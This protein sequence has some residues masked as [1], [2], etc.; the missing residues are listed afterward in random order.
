MRGPKQTE[1]PQCGI[2]TAFNPATYRAKVHLPLLST[3]TDWIRVGS[4]YVGAGW[5]LRTPL[6]TGNEVL[7][8]FPNGD[9]N[10]GII[11]CALWS[12]DC[13][14]T[15]Q[16]GGNFCLVHES[17]SLLRFG[18]DGSIVIRASNVAIERL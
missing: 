1:L 9:L 13:D 4:T 15:P 17:G 18:T 8:N 14:P 5:G 11:V 16:E 6:H 3:E 7:V 2:V 10:N 12:E